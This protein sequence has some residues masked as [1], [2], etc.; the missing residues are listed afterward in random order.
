MNDESLDIETTT[1]TVDLLRHG[2]V[3]GGAEGL[4]ALEEPEALL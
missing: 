1:T 3:E 2:D 4:E